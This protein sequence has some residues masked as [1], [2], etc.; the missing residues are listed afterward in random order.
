MFE[1]QIN[2]LV[3]LIYDCRF[4]GAYNLELLT[5]LCGERSLCVDYHHIVKRHV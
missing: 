1:I 3:F 2:S 4:S 5:D